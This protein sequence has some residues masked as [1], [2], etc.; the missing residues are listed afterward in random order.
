MQVSGR[1]MYA[2]GVSSVRRYLLPYLYHRIYVTYCLVRLLNFAHSSCVAYSKCKHCMTAHEEKGSV[3]AKRPN[4]T[5]PN[6]E[7]VAAGLHLVNSTLLHQKQEK[8]R[9]KEG[10]K[11]E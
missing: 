9:K 7:P 1:M 10:G 5:Y 4:K 11:K 6:T 3:C 2:A 8:E